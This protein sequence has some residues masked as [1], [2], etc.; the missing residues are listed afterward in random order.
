MNSTGTGMTSWSSLSPAHTLTELLSEK[1]L[2]FWSMGFT[3]SKASQPRY[4]MPDEFYQNMKL[5]LFSGCAPFVRL[6]LRVAP[7]LPW[8][9]IAMLSCGIGET[10]YRL[11]FNMFNNLQ[12]PTFF[13]IG[14]LRFTGCRLLIT[15]ILQIFGALRQDPL[16][17]R[18]F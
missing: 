10:L 2:L 3:Q 4:D 16:P 11:S 5:A 7:D 9:A 14:I 8:H 15:V 13:H 12:R 17:L 6:A 18:L 1:F